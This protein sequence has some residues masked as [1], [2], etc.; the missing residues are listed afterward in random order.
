MTHPAARI[1][2]EEHSA[3]GAMLRS[4]RMLIAAGPRDE[5]ERFFDV[6]RTM[7]FYIDEF[8]ERLHHPKESRVLFPKVADAAPELVQ[9]IG[10]LHADH[11]SGER[12]ARE[13]QHQLLAW[14]L[15]GENHRQTFVVAAKSYIEFY[16]AHM[17]LEEREILPAA[18]RVHSDAD[19]QEMDEVFARDRDP[20]ASGVADPCYDRLF[21][22]IV[23][24][25]PGPMPAGSLSCPA[26]A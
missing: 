6:L 2:R 20:F 26:Q 14:E 23:L 24:G 25:M 18:E 22:R 8:P 15:L 13:L 21:S 10:R 17:H 12:R 4:M 11:A 5:R 19:L 3:L 16:L 7:L 9:V 1:I